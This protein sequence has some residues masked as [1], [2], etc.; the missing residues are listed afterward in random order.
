MSQN[1]QPAKSFRRKTCVV[2]VEIAISLMAA[3]LVFAQQAEKVEKIEI[4]GTRLPSPTLEGPSPVSVITA[5]D[6]Q[7]SGSR[8]VENMLNNL[9]QVFADQNS[10]V[11][12]GASG[13]A[14]VNLRGLGITR[15]L[16]LMN[17]RR[18]PYGDITYGGG[19]AA[20]LNMIPTSLIK[21][22]E[23]LTGGAGAVYGSDA[24]AGVVNFIMNDKFQG[25]QIDL[26]QSG[27]NHNQQNTRGVADIVNGRAATNPSQFKV[28]GDKGFD[29]KTFDM[30]LTMGSN[31]DGGKGNATM[32]FSY[33]KQDALLQSER[34]FSA[35][36]IAGGGAVFSCGG[37]G[38]NATGRITN[39]A[40]GQVWTNADASGTAR[41]FNNALDQYNY[42]PLNH[43]QR[44]DERYNVA[45][46]ANYDVHPN[47]KVYMEFNFGDD[48]TRAQIAPG[49][50]F[51]SVHTVNFDNPLL[52]ASWR[53]ALGLL[54]PGDST[55]IV[56]QRRNVEGGGRVSE[57]RHTTFRDVVG[58]KGEIAK[59]SYDVFAENAKMIYS[60]AQLNYF[61]NER[62]DRA[63]N[64]VNRNGVAVCQSVIDGTDPNCLPYNP[65]RNGGVT[66][67]QLSYLQ[68]GGF[69]KGS[70]QQSVYG[71]SVSADLGDYGIKFPAAKSGVAVAFG[72]ER[73]TEKIDLDTDLVVSTG[74]LSGSGGATIGISGKY[75]VNDY[76][77]EVRAPLIEGAPMADLVSVN[78]SVRRSSYSTDIDTNT[79]GIGADWAPNKLV[80]VRGTYQDAVRAANLIE[81]FQAQGNNL[82]DMDSDPCA[83]PTPTATRAECAR[84]GVTAAQ[85]GNIQDSPAGQYNFLQ[86]GN[87]GLK[88]EKAKTYTIGLVLTPFK[89]F[90]ATI[91]YYD[92]KIDKIIGTVSPTTTLNQCLTTGAFCN[93]ITRDRLGTLWLLNDGRIVATNQNLGSTR[94]SGVDLSANYDHALP[95]KWGK[96]NL[97]YVGTYLKKLETE[98]IPGLGKY[99]CVGL[100]GASKCGG[101]NPEW[102]HHLR[103]TWMTPWDVNLLVGYRFAD[104]VKVQES[105]GQTLLAGTFNTVEE[106]L[107]SANYVDIA[108]TWM[109]TKQF[110]LLG[111]INNL[112]DRDPPITSAQG[113]SVFGNGNTFPGS[114]DTLGRKI[115]L[116]G[117]YKF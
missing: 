4:T 110:T 58:V 13:T 49:G 12:N 93:L 32:F 6:I 40:N 26:N 117:T 54:A 59:W 61:L 116:S 100:Y 17:G 5:A 8:N 1:K 24:V 103:A 99:D 101:P 73:R 43:Y 74:S 64:V 106:R 39:L 25:V 95:G 98:E 3:P 80:R 36:A 90:S 10:T 23:I 27:Y 112:F 79:Y 83:G 60:Q 19:S 14:T 84:T 9:P 48:F 104:A 21:R 114:Y 46:F 7:L 35:C 22:V 109:V 52:S 115:F 82:F 2:A 63:M 72:I 37:S 111:G 87:P 107:H 15:T 29:G 91:D 57:Y 31:F 85:Y 53:T 88:P 20:D 51:G 76:F 113:P 28:P 67:D 44:P 38:T 62:I 108:A 102:R 69:Y 47:A 68:Q 66:A 33:K 86:G 71:G 70:A 77:A 75:T 92:I 78:A 94:T 97:N 105:S 42:G 41:R 89:N 56:L 34:D 96:L 30:A 65:W 81:L 55:D 16:T 18:L 11:A 45:A 50:A